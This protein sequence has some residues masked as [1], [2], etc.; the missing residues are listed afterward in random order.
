MSSTPIP[1]QE[2]LEVHKLLARNGHDTVPVEYPTIIPPIL[3]ISK[4]GVDRKVY[5]K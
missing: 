1:S 5:L 2:L 4:L 3:L